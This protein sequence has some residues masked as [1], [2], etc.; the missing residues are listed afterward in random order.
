MGNLDEGGETPGLRAPPD[1]SSEVSEGSASSLNR[2]R[3]IFWQTNPKRTAS[4]LRGS[5]K[6]EGIIVGFSHQ[7]VD[8]DGLLDGKLVISPGNSWA[9][10][11][12]LVYVG[13]SARAGFFFRSH[14]VTTELICDAEIGG[15]LRS[16][17]GP[18]ERQ[19]SG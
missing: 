18:T 7:E 10:R 5:E 9:L 2:A 15:R 1:S 14:F 4:F 3:A 8:Y 19:E 12:F 6:P 17:R 11:A 13:F 16:V